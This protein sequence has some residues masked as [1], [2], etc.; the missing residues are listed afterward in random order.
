LSTGIGSLASVT[1][2]RNGNI[3]ITQFYDGASQPSILASDLAGA[4]FYG[5]A[6]DDGFPQS[7]PRLLTNG[8][9]DWT[10][11]TGDGTGAA[12]DQTGSGT[13]YFFKAPCCI[14]EFPFLPSDF[15]QVALPGGTLVSRTTGLLQAGDDPATNTGQWPQGPAVIANVGIGRFAVNP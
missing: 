12:T 5:M 13:A 3:Q 6:Q 10:G 11:V 4:M 15:Y 2:N 8:N 7:D 14:N 9:L 1:G